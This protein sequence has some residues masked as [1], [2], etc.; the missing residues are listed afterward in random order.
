MKRKLELPNIE[1]CSI[2]I[3]GLGYVGLP[4]AVAISENKIC[5]VSK[6]TLRRKVVGFDISERRLNELSASFDK[7]NEISSRKLK[8]TSIKFT[9][10]QKILEKSD[11]FIVTVPTP[12]DDKKNPDLDALKNATKMIGN[13]L[14]KKNCEVKP[15]IIYESTVFPGATEEICVPIIEKYSGLKF[16]YDFVCGFSPERI[17]PGDKKHTLDTVMKVTSGSDKE[18]SNWINKFYSSFIS[19]G[20]FNAASIKIAE[21]AKILENTQRDL[22]IALMNE[23]A[24]ILDKLNIDTLDV[25]EAAATKWNFLP[26]KPGLVGGH[27]IGVDPYY[28]TFKAKEEGYLAKTILAGRCIN[29]AMGVWVTEKLI[30]MM[31]E[32]QKIIEGSKV[33]ILGLAFKENCNDIRNTKIEDIISHLEK[34]NIKPYIV[35]PYVDLDY[36]NKRFGG[37]VYPDFPKNIKFEALIVAVKHSQFLS[38][39]RNDWQGLV[40]KDG[41]IFDLKGIV[42]RDLC[43]IRI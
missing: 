43:P 36:A 23:M 7:T 42:P 9:N 21:A 5:K 31:K 8:E 4:L 17:N 34:F 29:D 2:C 1:N 3:I 30:Q 41:L 13:I 24:I 37:K 14:H 19:A 10:D 26:F 6:K 32:K 38:L 11:V 16:N 22:N 39:N 27:C 40:D 25:L 33:L 18:S 35:D 12:I 20:T 15:I 28:L